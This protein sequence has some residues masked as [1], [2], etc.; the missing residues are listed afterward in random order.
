LTLPEWDFLALAFSY[1]IFPAPMSH[2]G[3]ARRRKPFA[4][5]YFHLYDI[6]MIRAEFHCTCG[7]IFQETLLETEASKAED[8]E[9]LYVRCPRCGEEATLRSLDRVGVKGRRQRDDS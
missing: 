9:R 7:F 3:K 5:L 8:F 2:I 1:A 6:S 4:F